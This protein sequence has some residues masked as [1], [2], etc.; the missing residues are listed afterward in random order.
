MA[1]TDTQRVRLWLDVVLREAG[2]RLP[3]TRTRSIS[4]SAATPKS[5][6]FEQGTESPQGKVLDNADT[7]TVWQQPIPPSDTASTVSYMPQRT[8]RLAHLRGLPAKRVNESER[9]PCPPVQVA[10]GRSMDDAASGS[11][12]HYTPVPNYGRKPYMRGGKRHIVPSSDH[13]SLRD[14][15]GF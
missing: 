7:K 14:I 8:T 9:Q 11:T 10:D 1:S 3:G 5:V 15:L 6:T 13:D 2:Q 4:D 12:S